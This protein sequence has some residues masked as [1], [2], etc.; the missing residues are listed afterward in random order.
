[1][2]DTIWLELYKAIR[3][4]SKFPITTDESVEVMRVISAVKKGTRF[5]KR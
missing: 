3:E 2:N 4:G 1:M 5:Q